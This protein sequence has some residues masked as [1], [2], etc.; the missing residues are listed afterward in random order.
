MRKNTCKI[1]VCLIIFI[2]LLLYNGILNSK[3]WSPWTQ[4]EILKS[5]W[6]KKKKIPSSYYRQNQVWSQENRLVFLQIIN[7][8]IQGQDIGQGITMR[9]S[10]TKVVQANLGIFTEIQEFPD[11]FRNYSS[12]FS[13]LCVNLPHWKTE[14]YSEHW[15]N[16]NQGA[17][18]EP[19]YI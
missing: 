1:N 12:I 10:K 11:I 6:S 14:A 2:I 17:Y 16:E 4:F 19:W 13:T 9:T 8:E 7:L 15:H 5:I 18:L 3:P